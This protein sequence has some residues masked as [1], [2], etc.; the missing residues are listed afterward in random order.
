MEAFLSDKFAPLIEFTN[1]APKSSPAQMGIDLTG[2]AA[3]IPFLI[4]QYKPDWQGLINA[5]TNQ[6]TAGKLSAAG[7]Q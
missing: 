4:D 3:S 1:P 5:G 7:M 2:S 6:I